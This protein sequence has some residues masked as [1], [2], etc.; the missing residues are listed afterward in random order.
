MVL[1]VDYSIN[2]TFLVLYLVAQ[3]HEELVG[4]GPRYCPV[5]VLPDIQLNPD[6][7]NYQYPLPGVFINHELS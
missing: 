1:L 7:V 4:L 6:Q 2:P 5:V 3:T